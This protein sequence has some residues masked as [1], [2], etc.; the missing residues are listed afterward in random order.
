MFVQINEILEKFPIWK[1][2]KDQ[3]HDLFLS[4]R[5]VAGYLTGYKWI[6]NL[7]SIFISNFF[8]TFVNN[9]S[10]QWKCNLLDIDFHAWM[11]SDQLKTVNFTSNS[12]V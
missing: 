10:I 9:F 5:P 4:D 2:Y 12:L 1:E 3:K 7:Y 11:G 6:Y 8:T